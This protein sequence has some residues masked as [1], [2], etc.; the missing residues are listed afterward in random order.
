[1]FCKKCGQEI[2][3]LSMY[4]P[5][6]GASQFGVETKTPELMT[7]GSHTAKVVVKGYDNMTNAIT[8]VR[9]V[10]GLD[11]VGAR[12]AISELP[13]VLFTSL[14]NEAAE[15]YVRQLKECGVQAEVEGGVPSEPVSVDDAPA[16]PEFDKELEAYEKEQELIM[17][18]PKEEPAPEP[19]PEPEPAHAP[20]EEPA[21]AAEPSFEE[22][23]DA[24]LNTQEEKK[25]EPEIVLTLPSEPEKKSDEDFDKEMA[26]FLA[27]HKE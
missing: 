21:P 27:D 11:F 17:P 24:F 1:M 8:I 5:E 6:C 26:A 20:A 10:T 18:M 23:M 13:A 19:E 9:D 14:S 22:Q 12:K 3:D 25:E 15:E 16:D 4:C 2:P 7:E